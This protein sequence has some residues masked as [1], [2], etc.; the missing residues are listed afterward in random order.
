[1]TLRR[2]HAVNDAV[3]AGIR[4]AFPGADVIVHA[5]PADLDEAKPDLD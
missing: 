5:E 2:A 3:E 1:M 4:E